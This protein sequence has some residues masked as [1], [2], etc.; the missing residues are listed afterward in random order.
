M[1][2]VGIRIRNIGDILANELILLFKDPAYLKKLIEY[3]AVEHKKDETFN[4]DRG[5]FYKIFFQNFGDLYLDGVFSFVEKYV[6]SDK[7]A[8]QRVA[9]EIVYGAIM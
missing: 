7:D 4:M 2:Y 5:L 6:A 1:G 9:A 3:T 8:E